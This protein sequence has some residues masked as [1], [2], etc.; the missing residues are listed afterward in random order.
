MTTSLSVLRALTWFLSCDIDYAALWTHSS[1]VIG[2]QGHVIGT[3]AFQIP[4][5]H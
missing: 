4:D 2:P 1:T 3:A 5:E